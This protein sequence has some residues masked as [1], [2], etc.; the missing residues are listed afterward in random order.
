[1]ACLLD[2]IEAAADC[3]GDH[4]RRLRLARNLDQAG[5]CVGHHLVNVQVRI[6]AYNEESVLPRIKQTRLAHRQAPEWVTS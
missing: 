2:T 4:K 1:M 3:S 5:S 6:P